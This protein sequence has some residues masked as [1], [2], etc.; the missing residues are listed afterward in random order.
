MAQMDSVHR[1]LLILPR[2]DLSNA[3]ADVVEWRMRAHDGTRLWGLRALSP[4][5]PDPGGV[6]VREVAAS[7]LPTV[8]LETVTE[9]WA[10]FVLQV[11]A[12][13]R[14][15]DRVLDL[16]RVVQVALTTC[17][18]EAE[19]VRLEA[20]VA[21]E[22]GRRPADEVVIADRLLRSGICPTT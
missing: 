18:V 5:H 11:P 3:F 7:E 2:T 15:E 13:R 19:A 4:F 16:L 8:R 21:G 1:G 10:E 9:G 12:G 14:L 17:G 22:D 20:F 6:C